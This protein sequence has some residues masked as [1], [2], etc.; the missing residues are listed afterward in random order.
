INPEGLQVVMDGWDTAFR[1]NKRD[2]NGNGTF[3]EGIDY[4]PG[5]GYDRDGVDLNRNYS[6]NWIHGDT[7]WAPG[8]EE[9]WDYYRGPAPF[10]EGGT[11]AVRDLAEEQH[12]I[13][14]I[15]WHSS[16]TG[17][18]SEKVFYS[19]EWA[20][21]K[22]PPDFAV[23]Q[24]I[25]ETVAGLIETETGAGHYEPSPSTGRKG[26]AQDWFYQTYG[27][28]QLLIE[29]GTYDIQPDS[30]IVEDT[31]ER[32]SAGAYWL[33]NRVLGYQA[34]AAMLTGNISDSLTG[35]PLIAE[36]IVEEKHASYFAPRLSDE[37]YGRFWRVLQP[38]TYN[39]QIR[40]KGYEEK[41]IN[42]I[43]VNNSCWT[44]LDI[45]L[46]PLGEVL[47]N[48]SVTCNGSP[49]PAQIIVYDIE[50]DT[51]YTENGCFEFS[52]Y[53]GEHKI[54]IT[55][56]GCIPYIDTLE[57]VLGTWDMDVELSPEVVIFYENWESGLVSW[58]ITGDWN[59][60][61]DSYEGN[62]SITDSPDDF[63]NSNS[64][65]MI[66]T[67]DPINLNGVANDVMLS[68]WHKYHIEWDNDICSVEISCDGT[69]WEEIASFSGVQQT[70]QRILLSLTEWT[71]SSIY[72]RFK[73]TTDETLVD[74]G[75]IIDDIKIISSQGN[76]IDENYM[77][78]NSFTLYQNYPNPFNPDNIRTTTISFN[79]T[80][81]LRSASPGQAKIEIYNVK[82]Q[83]VKQLSIENRQSSIIWDGKDEKGEVVSS[84]IYFYQLQIEDK[85]IDTKK[86]LLLK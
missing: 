44:D 37:L 62:Y 76:G 35:E 72:L 34:D 73:L 50:N 32:C 66:T 55:S 85:I 67:K 20:G 48:G 77:P 42:N 45:E 78:P 79:L 19:F 7:L 59:L 2:C 27:T 60:C 33:L 9:L 83:L 41:V 25:G 12:F 80:T 4:V 54:Q 24:M 39:L 68:F 69:D 58:N 10:S 3:I 16:R 51:I 11:Q 70:W 36:V 15:N 26:N 18:F 6:F 84:G 29:C 43:T 30:T 82:G 22:R 46:V 74:P 63:Y 47:V 75:W 38:G 8:G 1:K 23:N 64:T 31:C 57:F 71:N 5:P 28:T 52:T 65:V 13:F 53:E 21:V 40:K 17:N 61:E 56:E 81:R 14:S 49:V 86:C